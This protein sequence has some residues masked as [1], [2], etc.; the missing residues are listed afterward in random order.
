MVYIKFDSGIVNERVTT[1]EACELITKNKE[2]LGLHYYVRM[3]TNPYN[4]GVIRVDFLDK[5]EPPDSP[6]SWMIEHV[7]EKNEDILLEVADEN[8]TGR[9]W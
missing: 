8:I 3:V 1:K 4:R 2:L 9:F 5:A 7:T 6:E